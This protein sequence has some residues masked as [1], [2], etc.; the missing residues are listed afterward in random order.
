MTLDEIR[1]SDKVLLN[2]TDIAAILETDPHS[3]RIMAHE[4]PSALGFPVIVCGDK[5]RRVKIPRIQ[6]LRFLG[7]DI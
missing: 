6:F 5:G 7:V 2:A 4:K 3:I 1:A